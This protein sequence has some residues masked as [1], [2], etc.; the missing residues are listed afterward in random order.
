MK[1]TTLLLVPLT[2]FDAEWRPGAVAGQQ[3]FALPAGVGVGKLA[4]LA[5]H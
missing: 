4:T 2:P 5:S 3:D 1:I